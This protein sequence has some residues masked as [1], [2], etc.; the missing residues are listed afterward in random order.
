VNC[1]AIPQ[2]LLESELFGYE[3]GAFTGAYRQK[4]GKFELAQGGTILLDEIVEMSLAP[5]SKLL[6]VLQDREFSR[7]GGKKDIRVDV[8]VIAATNRNVEESVKNGQF[9]E[10]LYYRMNVVNIHIPPLRERKEEIPI[11]VKYF[12]DKFAT[13]Y[14]KKIKPISERAMKSFIDHPW[15]GNVR[16]LEN[17]LHRYV[18]LGIDEALIDDFILPKE[19]AQMAGKKNDHSTRSS[20]PSLREVQREAV[21]RAECEVISKVLRRTNWNRKKSAALLNIS[22][23]ALLYK[24][25][26]H[27]VLKEQFIGT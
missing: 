6:Q 5:Q 15:T 17:V 24:I 25:K 14:N 2:E 18:A 16:E 12:L 11:L 27:E 19:P 20:R 7:L 23:K 13:K 26:E 9:R 4:P 10:D 21:L 3:K 22:Y 1:A 8:R